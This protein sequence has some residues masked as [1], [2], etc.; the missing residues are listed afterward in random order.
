[1]YCVLCTVYCVLCTVYCVLCTVHCV[2]C[3]VYCVYRGLCTVY[4]DKGMDRQWRSERDTHRFGLSTCAKRRVCC[5]KASSTW[6]VRIS[7]CRS[8]R[9]VVRPPRRLLRLVW[10]WMGNLRST[11]QRERERESRGPLSTLLFSSFLFSPLFS[12]LFFSPLSLS[13]SLSVFLS[14]SLSL[15]LYLSIYLSLYLSISLIFLSFLFMSRLFF[16]LLLSFRL[17]SEDTTQQNAPAP[18]AAAAR[19][20][21]AAGATTVTFTE[22]KRIADLVV[23]HLRACEEVRLHPLVAD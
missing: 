7:C 22:Y 16:L 23:L 13:F 21:T 9:A 19:P 18:Q 11:L 3:T 6:R 8:D 15:S 4:C 1:V 10:M 14:F 17:S 12:M 2:L 20:K 5:A